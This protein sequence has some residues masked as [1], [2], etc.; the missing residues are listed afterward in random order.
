[1]Y[2]D[3]AGTEPDELIGIFQNITSLNL[4]SSAFE[5]V[6]PINIVAFET[7]VFSAG[8]A[9]AAI[10]TLTRPSST[11]GQIG[12][13][14]NLADG[15]AT[16]PADYVNNPIS[17][18]FSEGESSKTVTIP[19]IDDSIREGTETISLT[20]TNPT[21]GAILGVQKN[22]TLSIV[23]ND[24]GLQGQYFN[25]Y[26]NDNFSFFQ[27]NQPVF[28]RTD[29]TINF[30]SNSTDWNLSSVPELANLDTFSVIW[31]GFINISI[32]GNYTFFLNS[33][34]S[35]YLFLDDAVQTPSAANAT[36]NNGGLHG[37]VEKSGQ[38]FLQ[39]GFHPISIIYGENAVSNVAQFSWSSTDAGIIKQIVSDSVLY[40]SINIQTAQPGTLSFSNSQFTVNENGMSVVAINIVR[41]GGVDGAISATVNLTNVTATAPGDYNNLPITVNFADK[42]TSK[43][44]VVP[45]VDD[46]IY[47]KD[48]TVNLI[49]ANPTGGSTLGTQSTAV[50]TIIDDDAIPG[51]LAF[52]QANYS[53][54]ENGT[55]VIT[56]TVTRT[57]GSNK[58]VSATVSLTNGSA[59][60]S[61][62][63]SNN[64][65]A[66]DFADGDTTSKTIVIPIVSDTL[67]EGNET[68]NL[69]LINPTGGATLGTQKSAT[70]TIID[71][72][73]Y[74]PTAGIL[75]F[76]NP[77]YEL[78][79]AGVPNGSVTINRTSGSEGAIST[80]ILLA[81]GTATAGSDYSGSPITVNFANGETTKTVT[82]PIANDTLVE[83]TE[84]FNLTLTNP[85]GGS[86]IDST[87]NTSIVS[88]LDDDVQLNFS[89]ATYRVNENGTAITEINVTLTGQATDA[90][91]V[92]LS[93]TDGTA[94]GCV[95]A[96]SSVN[97]DFYNGTFSIDFAAGETSKA[98]PV[99][100]ASLGGTNTLRIRD[101]AKVEG[102]EYFTIN[103]IDP[104]GGATVGNQ[105]SA[106]VTIVD[107][108][109]LPH[110]SVTLN[111][112]AIAENAGVGAVTGTVTRD[113][114]SNAP[115]VVALAS[116]NTTAVT[117]AQQVTIAAGQASA[118][119]AIDAV[120]NNILDGTRNVIITA[121]PLNV[122][123]NLLLTAGAGSGNLQV[124][125]DESPTL[126]LTVDRE[127]VAE[128]GTAIGTL[129]RNTDTSTALV[130]TI[131]S[132]NTAA[133]TIPTTVTIPIGQTA[134]NFNVNGVDDGV[135]NGNKPITLTALA[136]GFTSSS[137]AITISDIS[138][139]DLVIT[140]LNP[141]LPTYTG[142]QA[143][144]N[145]RLENKGIIAATAP[146]KVNTT[147]SAKD[148][149][150]DRV[151]LSKDNIL[152]SADKLLGEFPFAGSMAPG[153]FYDRNISYYAPITP[154]QYYLIGVTDATNKV[155]E[156]F[157]EINNTVIT[158][159]TVIP[160]YQ[161][162][163]TT[164]TTIATIG[165]P[166]TL[167]GSA[168]STKDSSPIA[169]EFV[170]IKVENKGIIR[171]LDALTDAN[172]NFTKQFVPLAG[173]GGTYN[174]NAYFTG[175]P[176]EDTAPEATFELVGMRFEQNNQ[177]LP[178]VTQ[179]I[180]Q[181]TTY[182]GLVKL[183]NLSDVAL[184]GLT[185]SAIDAPSN[186][187]VN[188]TPQKSTLAGNEEIGVNYSI[189]VPDG[190]I[191]H[192]D[193]KLRLTSAEGV[194]SNLS[195]TIDVDPIVPKLVASTNI[196]NSGMLRGSQTFV[197]VEVTNQGGDT[198]KN[199]KVLLPDTPWLALTSPPTIAA[200]APGA[201]T[202]VTIRLNP[203][204]N[205]PLTEYKGNLLL[206]VEGNDGD[207]T[208]P[209]NFRAVSSATGEVRI[210]VSDEL[211]Y[212]VDG[213][214][215]LKGATVNLLDYFT[216]E[217][218]A[219]AVSDDTGFVDFSNIKE[220]NYSLKVNADKHSNF[221]QTI[222][223][224]AGKVE[225]VDAF[226]S[227]Q[228]VQYIWTVTPTEIQDKYTIS[229][230]SVFETNVPT[231]T[232]VVEPGSL[233][234]TD[235]TTIGQ[236]KQIDMK[237]TNYGLI[238]A[239]N[240]ALNISNH[241]FYKVEPLLDNFG[242]IGAKS[243]LTIPVKITRIADFN[244][245]N[246]SS[247]GD[248][249]ASSTLSIP[250][251][252]TYGFTYNFPCGG[253]DINLAVAIPVTGL[254][255]NCGG[256]AGIPSGF[257]GISGGPGG[258]SE[259]FVVPIVTISSCTPCVQEL[260]QA[261]IKCVIEYVDITPIEK[262]VFDTYKCIVDT[263]VS[264]NDT[265]SDASYNCFK[266]AINCGFILGNTSPIRRYIEVIE[267]EVDFI[268]AMLKCSKEL[269]P[270]SLNGLSLSDI[271]GNTAALTTS[272]V[273][274]ATVKQFQADFAR[275]NKVIDSQI[276]L[277]GDIVWLK[278][279][280]SE[281]FASWLTAFD[282]RSTGT[283]LADRKISAAER[284]EL[285][286]IP[287]PSA[288]TATDVHKFLD[289]WNRSLDNWSVGRRNLSDIPT[290]EST[291]FIAIDV[292]TD[293]LALAKAA[294]GE[295][296][297]SGYADP[298]QQLTI[299]IDEL[300]KSLE[301]GKDGNGACAVVRLKIDQDAVMTR[302][303]FI[304]NLEI[305]NNN[306]TSLTNLS[307]NIQVKDA[308][309]KVVNDLFGID[310][311]ILK[312]ITA[313]DGNGI[314]IGDNPNTPQKEGIGSAQWTF[315]P[316]NL[317]APDVPTQYTIGGTLAY[318]E[319]GRAISVPLLSSSITVNPQAE[320]YLNYFHQRDVFGDDPFTPQVETSVPYELGILIQNKGKGA[321]K[322]L[323]ITSGQPKIVD[324]EKGLLID[325]NIVGSQVN[326]LD[327][328]P[329][330]KV[331]FGN[332]GAGQTAEADWL[333]KSSLQGKF[334]DYKASFEHVNSL[335]KK[336]LS[337]IKDVQIHELTHTVKAHTG[338]DKLSDYLVNDV[339]DANFYPDT[340]Y[341]STG[342]TAPVKT[343]T[344][345]TTDG[346]V[347]I[348]DLEIQVTATVDT[349][350][351]YIRLTD[352]GD[353]QFKVKKVFRADG[354]E[355]NIEN[356]WTT[357][358]TFPAIGRP[359]YEN[360]LSLF[361][362]NATAG[363][364]KYTVFYASGDNTAPKV[365][366]I[367]DVDPNPRT[368]STTSLD[369][370]FTKAIKATTFDFNDFTLTRDGGANLI[371]S[372]I[373][374]SQIN[375]TT[376]RIDNLTSITG[377]VGQYL[378]S[379]N[380]SGISDIEGLAGVGTVTDSW[381]VNGD[382]PTVLKL[383][384]I[385]AN[386]R[387]TPV[388]SIIVTFTA[389]LNS[390]TFD[391]SDILLTRDRG[392]NLV[393]ADVTITQINSSTYQINGLTNLTKV[394]GN[395]QILIQAN[396]VQDTTGN[397]GIGGKGFNWTLGG[398]A[399]VV[400]DIINLQVNPRN[401]PVSSLDVKLSESIDLTTFTSDDITL[402]LNEGANLITNNV[403]V[404]AVDNI[405]YR[406]NGLNGITTADG[407]YKLTVNGIGIKDAFGNV[408]TGTQSET[409]LMDTIAPLTPTNILVAGA[410]P[411]GQ[412]LLNSLTP[413]ISGNL[414]E[415]GS[416]VFF[417]DKTTGENLGQATVTGQTFTKPISLTTAG[418]HKLE[419]SVEDAA[420]NTTRTDLNLFVDTAQ[421]TILEFLNVP[422]KSVSP[423]DFIDVRFSELINLSTFDRNDLTLSRD[424]VNLTL[425]NS[426]TIE[427][428]TGTTYRIR[429]LQDLTTSIGAYQLKVA[430]TTLQDRAGNQGDA[431]KNI[432][433]S[434][435]PPP[436]PGI[437]ITQTNGNTSITE[438][439][440]TDT[441]NLILRTQPTA[442][443]TINLTVGTQVTTDKA[444]LTFTPSNWNT[445][446]TVTIIAVDDAITE[447]DR[448]ANITHT[449]NSSDAQYNAITIPA[450]TV[451]ITDNDGGIRGFLWEDIDG[452]G[453]K[454]G[455][456]NN[457]ADRIVYLDNNKNGQID[458]TERTTTTDINGEYT[459]INLRPGSYTVAEVLPTGWYQTYPV[460][461]VSTSA[462]GEALY[463]PSEAL[464]SN[465]A[466]V[467][468]TSATLTNFQSFA[469]DPN[470]VDIKGQGYAT[471][472][473]D[474]GADLD[475]SYFGA[476]A[477][478]DGV[479]DRIIYQH[480]FADNDH[481][482]SDRTGHG[483]HVASIAA[484]LAPSANLII[485]K[486]FKDSGTGSFAD[487]EKALQWV[488]QNTATYNI[489][490]VNLSLGDSQN[491]NTT[492]PRY[493]I[494][495][496]I[497]AIS[498]QNVIIAAA[499]GN[500]FYR[501][502]S[503]PSV[504][505][506]AADPNTIA[507]GA[508]W[509]GNF[510]GT[511][512]FSSGA[513][514]YS[515]DID[516]IASFSQRD[517]NLLDVFA[518]GVFISGANATGGNQSLGGTSQATPFVA[519]IAVLAQQIALEKLGRKLTVAEF[520][521][522]LDSTSTI[523]TDGDDENDNVVNTSTSYPRIDLLNLAKGVA[524]FSGSSTV[525]GGSNPN[526]NGGD[527]PTIFGSQILTHLVTVN[528]GQIV[529]DK[530][531]GSR[532]DLNQANSDFGGDR[533]SDILWRHS[534]GSVYAYQMNGSSVV[535][536]GFIGTASDDWV[537]AGTGDFDA[538]GKADI[539]WRNSISGS[540]YVWQIDG[541][542]KV[543]EGG[544]R[545]VS[546]DWQIS[547][548]GDFN[549]D[550]KSDILWRNTNG[551]TYI[552]QMN[553]LA[554]ADEGLV[555]NVS[556]DWKIAGTGDFNADGKSDILWRNINTGSTY[557]YL[558][559]SISVAAEAE[560][561]Q[562]A[563][564]WVIEGI[565]DFNGDGKSDIL[566]RN[567]TSGTV[568]I[569]QMNGTAINGEGAIGTVP[570]YQGWTIAGT[571]DYNGDSKADILWR[572]DSGLTY[573]WTMDGLNK[574]E[575]GSIR[576]VDNSWQIVTSI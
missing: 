262:C 3:K 223:L 355:V 366:Q 6:T 524:N 434:I 224:G 12:V 169:F 178:S 470:F 569:Y 69:A 447:G 450:V 455:S 505:Y 310:N 433:F 418:S 162:N 78:N 137:K 40:P 294:F 350:W 353:G 134:V 380:A 247:A 572:N 104:T 556:N 129:T 94:K 425:P 300:K 76:A 138:V 148:P 468:A 29:Q 194:T 431:A 205:L 550:G 70:L 217:V 478:G 112:S 131:A 45:I 423:I 124:T 476:D 84:T 512:S 35:S 312:N 167:K 307:V 103:L 409:W 141:A 53:V 398:T 50:L 19:I 77:T 260:I 171:E 507:V 189:T 536:E 373:T 295:S 314:L 415:N 36:I 240:A 212:F 570:V 403:T 521:H 200:L 522:L 241:P 14:I 537:I 33:D 166:I 519:G 364:A 157:G 379:V 18:I 510:A 532:Q 466:G 308:S 57:G 474:T 560:V 498:A 575:E 179:K 328:S 377:N 527:S 37:S 231:P 128:T 555:R 297:L 74:I 17:V 269:Q 554:V 65:I 412:V 489:A 422:N 347:S 475:S 39:P 456:E 59:T 155:N 334:I 181:G 322:N 485:L 60:A 206:D 20:L 544:I 319:D 221:E 34:D 277:F 28:Q 97:N 414:A 5:Y 58:A 10:I 187:T 252:L 436:S 198:A 61:E 515:T 548:T 113:I 360:I 511:Q 63:Y 530:N 176:G 576:Q 136:N 336:E 316:T 27:Q 271:D 7:S 439:G 390:A 87:K 259:T 193:F 62:D 446:Q 13:T 549:G 503:A 201:S 471:V 102:D 546:N 163:V 419:L 202:K 552:Y 301:S 543:G 276:Q 440:N 568:Y 428:I 482:A 539:L 559:N 387:N 49:L 182:T 332:I 82:I 495:D 354:T 245:L 282:S 442:D 98:I 381:F 404:A 309:G 108:D 175:N 109:V 228:T 339:F 323:S 481:D 448:T 120:N 551:E 85:T 531:F 4:T 363:N 538:N 330:L 66:V 22:A 126:T 215:K 396:G 213:A 81:G 462:S 469:A 437:T 497:A 191:R 95:C 400:T 337:L 480:D 311:P 174:I 132:S 383:E 115:L 506:P 496:E 284:N 261:T 317:A 374:V 75:S 226:L 429:G 331:D 21:G 229:V 184:S 320:L 407:N 460:I 458:I 451:N 211:T 563:N 207:L 529:T 286:N 91:S 457:L 158:P 402:T 540:T 237:V 114:V 52:S 410:N 117:V 573:Q 472:I 356:I 453:E 357:D 464:S 441:Y 48:E 298:G 55:P 526:V 73:T 238:A 518:P 324:N 426:V 391:L 64:L 444:S 122:D 534:N 250:C 533:K 239:N 257:N 523:I 315:I 361:D 306:A 280:D 71:D 153:S 118:N 144:F 196:I 574:L 382:K 343:V 384:G 96:S 370:V 327:V 542:A 220:G 399:P 25:G 477:N 388:D 135:P 285:L 219:T 44:I 139:P 170:K 23:D 465:V 302:S 177:F 486:V 369:V 452:N 119:F 230:E 545:T 172:G 424:G 341:F 318:I 516:R 130:V 417:L 225:N 47:E 246:S 236:V 283:S 571:G 291:D 566:W 488:N 368:T 499:A 346:N 508:V 218:V 313:V 393:N 160:A 338:N 210:N 127:I 321:A 203:D 197:E 525:G 483:S 378:L 159:F 296:K 397:S 348:T 110:L 443:V 340:L 149:W 275:L 186:W 293:K 111:Q 164:A 413:T 56:V 180:V 133:V 67:V 430:A 254:S 248:L 375:L 567:S 299:D 188:I 467:S 266:L 513:K 251:G 265:A 106:K 264:C 427:L 421:P 41:S 395:Y 152:D 216:K 168:T 8:E 146:D 258:V 42:E 325:F 165:T 547:G 93:F 344:T 504:A 435:V 154:G 253:R 405:T 2:I 553:G 32:A 30:L 304:G 272:F 68:V 222:Q 349:G 562:V 445:V 185:G 140:Q 491:W 352:P 371:T 79:E 15:T 99:Q 151:Y 209:F 411:T 500:N 86:T 305:D 459:F 92:T 267:C 561:R 461:N 541:N 492:N 385:N 234:F 420:G 501:F 24:K 1:L 43:T 365:K 273:S 204:E 83:P 278:A 270:N 329:S 242:T 401:T 233:D 214:P 528:A 292:W 100:L 125:D 557:I 358:R 389:A 46:T 535:S 147:P 150:I 394:D 192:D 416:Q 105:G 143:T 232:L 72:D 235:L 263:P 156:G 565:D 351:S 208:V 274:T 121:T 101:D 31:K 90:V 367:V 408:G 279:S 345:A 142:S 256:F 290:G 89:G 392:A 517:A 26:F 289:R 288:I 326:G 454:N 16:A 303:A 116:S 406:I 227:R 80:T 161:A 463:V 333:L 520:R 287:L 38:V 514:D 558:M 502:N 449:V 493:G 173:E 359:V 107:N 438:N 342:G 490:S 243:S 145:Y 249:Q 54:N 123:S 88:I 473:I 199:I 487:L 509:A 386:R 376:F 362:Y 564:D 255:G 494:G 244:T 195:V 9:S 51:I 190:S 432:N 484:Q 11:V 479:A 372:A 183:Q 281:G 335:G 268:K